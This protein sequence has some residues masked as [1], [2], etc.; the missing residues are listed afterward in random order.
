MSTHRLA[1]LCGVPILS[2]SGGSVLV[3]LAR[4]TSRWSYKALH[5]HA[6]GVSLPAVVVH[7]RHRGG[8]STPLDI[9]V[10]DRSGPVTDVAGRICVAVH[11]AA[12]SGAYPSA[13]GELEVGVIAAALVV[14][15]G[16]SEPAVGHH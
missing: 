5:A 8:N 1:P 11:Q 14:D 2:V 6:C 15:L 16:G 3:S 7:E 12:A 13:V 9:P 4:A 10:G